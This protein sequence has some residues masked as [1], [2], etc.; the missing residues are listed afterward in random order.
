MNLHPRTLMAD[1]L[2]TQH[3]GLD[4]VSERNV[5]YITNC[6]WAA[7]YRNVAEDSARN[8]LH[9]VTQSDID[10]ERQQLEP[11][12]MHSVISEDGRFILSKCGII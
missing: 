10:G 4:K 5:V 8:R 7:V 12:K 9:P 3:P 6:I 11:F 1:A 2:I